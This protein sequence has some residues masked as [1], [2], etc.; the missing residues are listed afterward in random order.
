VVLAILLAATGWPGIREPATAR[1]PFTFAV[2]ADMRYWSGPGDHNDGQYFRG[3]V[4]AI[5]DYGPGAFMI[6][7][8][9]IDPPSDVYW[10]IT[11][12]LGVDYPWFPVVGNHE[13]PGEGVEDYE[14]ANMAWLRAYD[15]D[16][17]GFGSPPDI[18]R[19]GPPGCPQTTYSF[20]YAN[21]HFVVLNEYCDQDGDTASDGDVSDH[22]YYWL[23]SDLAANRKTHT[24]VIGHE[25]AFP[26]PDADNGRER[27][28]GESLDK[29]PTHRDRFWNLLRD[30]GVLAY[31]CGHTHNYSLW[32]KDGVWQ[33]DAGHARGAGD[34][35]APSTFLLIRVDGLRVRLDAYRDAH[36][37]YAYDD[38]HHSVVLYPFRTLLP[39]IRSGHS[40]PWP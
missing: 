22:L 25:P 4:E 2:T 38:I 24:F 18:V 34:T 3:A 9:D 29:D 17:N 20:N 28:V 15:Y 11:S 40:V 5:E 1:V 36:D 26:R 13:L 21:A 30:Q 23:V 16:L 31:I 37:D 8:G 6:S 12:T 19:T 14:G 33:V 39:S 7:P 27:H 35:G 10:S 32:L